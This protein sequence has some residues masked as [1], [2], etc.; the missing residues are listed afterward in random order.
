MATR[1][2]EPPAAAPPSTELIGGA[3]PACPIRSDDEL[4]EATT[5]I[6]SHAST[7][8][9]DPDELGYLDVLAT[10]VEHDQDEHHPVPPALDAQM[11]RH[12]IE[13][14]GVTQ[15]GAAA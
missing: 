8:Y 2:L 10:L 15:A 6:E 12:L 1:A 3:F 5:L 11:L 7:Y 9:L 4:A 14:R 13:S